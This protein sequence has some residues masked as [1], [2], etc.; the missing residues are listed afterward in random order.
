MKESSR[1]GRHI[2]NHRGT[3]FWKQTSISMVVNYKLLMYA[4]WRMRMWV[5]CSRGGKQPTTAVSIFTFCRNAICCH[6]SFWSVWQWHSRLIS[7]QVSKRKRSVVFAVRWERRA[8][9]RRHVLYVVDLEG[10]QS[11]SIAMGK[12]ETMTMQ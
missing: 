1:G 10:K 9:T 12:Y 2:W 11:P 6:L 5:L 7:S 4:L 3:I 8:H